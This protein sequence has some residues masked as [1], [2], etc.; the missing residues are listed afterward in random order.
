VFAS[1]KICNLLRAVPAGASPPAIVYAHLCNYLSQ[2]WVND[3]VVITQVNAALANVTEEQKE[4][5][6][7]ILVN[8]FSELKQ[9]RTSRQ[10]MEGI[11]QKLPDTWKEF[12]VD[13]VAP[14]QMTYLTP[15][16]QT[17]L[18]LNQEAESNKLVAEIKERWEK[19]KEGVPKNQLAGRKRK[20]AEDLVEKRE[21]IV[22]NHCK[23]T[24]S[25]KY[26]KYT[27]YDVLQLF[28]CSRC[29][30]DKKAPSLR[31]SKVLPS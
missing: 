31:L 18:F 29:V 5:M 27:V 22:C 19:E 6:H 1:Y 16:R 13:G 9:R 7:P 30:Y 10:T 23:T 4:K 25:C 2:H 21:A 12:V 20:F 11:F 15:V 3:A 24:V 17:L 14:P 26:A 28:F 8:F